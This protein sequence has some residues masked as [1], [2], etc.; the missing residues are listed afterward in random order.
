[1]RDVVALV[2]AVLLVFFALR[3]ATTL[4][5]DRRR[6]RDEREAIA[7]GG[8]TVLAEIPSDEG[9]V[10]FTED[11]ESFYLDDRPIPKTTIRAARVLINGAPIAVAARPGHQA[12]ATMSSEL[13]GQR[14]EGL[15]RDRWDV[16][17]DTE[18]DA[19]IVPCGA[20]REQISQELARSI[21][22]AVKRILE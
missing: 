7:A 11:A 1:M 19:V 4:T 15:A 6:R 5:R 16:A 21:F 17:I 22:D 13:I 8:R 9:L 18:H 10:F 3:L 14:P 12:A 2:I 20:I